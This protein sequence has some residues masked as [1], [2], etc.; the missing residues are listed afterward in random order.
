MANS[1]RQNLLRRLVDH[2]RRQRDQAV[3][4]VVVAQGRLSDARAI[5]H[6]RRQNLQQVAAQWEREAIS[7]TSADPLEL[8]FQ[9]I[10][11]GNVLASE[12]EVRAAREL[13]AVR[14]AQQVAQHASK[15]L[16]AAEGMLQAGRDA[17]LRDIAR[18][19]QRQVDD[20]LRP[21]REDTR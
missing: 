18:A 3:V 21:A 6:A 15:R 19:E 12:A 10:E 4:E 9:S 5:E 17:T 13:D 2:R 14:N 7:A 11:I 20:A 16:E 1:R 8:L